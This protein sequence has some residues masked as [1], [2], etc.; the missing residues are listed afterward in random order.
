MGRS[1]GQGDWAALFGDS[2]DALTLVYARNG[3]QR[4][5]LAIDGTLTVRDY[6]G[7]RRDRGQLLNFVSA[8]VRAWRARVPAGRHAALVGGLRAALAESAAGALPEPSLAMDEVPSSLSVHHP[9]GQQLGAIVPSNLL[10]GSAPLR[11]A[12][13]ELEALCV[14]LVSCRE[15]RSLPNPELDQ[16]PEEARRSLPQP[17]GWQRGV[18]WLRGALGAHDPAPQDDAGARAAAQAAIDAYYRG[19]AFAALGQLQPVE[20]LGASFEPA[21]F[22]ASCSRTGERAGALDLRPQGSSGWLS[23]SGFRPTGNV[24][25]RVEGPQLSA[26]REALAVGDLRALFRL[27]PEI[28]PFYC[29]ACDASFAASQWKLEQRSATSVAGTCPSGHRRSLCA[30]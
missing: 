3:D 14:L 1:D 28:V 23:L 13:A 21:S 22:V 16:W 7:P 17:N 12:C 29:P 25:R 26:A 10:Q 19:P 8:T 20:L 18:A 2:I 5:E 24:G 15:T 30:D 9:N 6:G 4:L 11:A 27:D